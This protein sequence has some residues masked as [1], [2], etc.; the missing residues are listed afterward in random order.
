MLSSPT[1]RGAL[2]KLT[3][4]FRSYTAEI[5]AEGKTKQLAKFLVWLRGFETELEKRKPTFTG[6]SLYAISC[7]FEI[8]IISARSTTRD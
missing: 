1:N 3:M 2:T 5:E 8:I 4:T 7:F 6:K